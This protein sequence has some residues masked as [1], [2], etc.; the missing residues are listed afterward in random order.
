VDPDR[1]AV[2][3]SYA[4]GH[5]IVLGAT[6]PRLG[7]VVAQVPTISGYQQSLR[8]VAPD[9]MPALEAVFADDERR[10]FTA[11]HRPPRPWLATTLGARRVSCARCRLVL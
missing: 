5:A 2:G 4:G 7:A 8:R 10:S 3:S 6:D 1:S 11:R 9:Q